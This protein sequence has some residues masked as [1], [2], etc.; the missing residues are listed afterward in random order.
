VRNRLYVV[1]FRRNAPESFQ[2]VSDATPQVISGIRSGAEMN[3]Q[4][5]VLAG[6]ERV[7]ELFPD[8]ARLWEDTS[9]DG[10]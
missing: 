2:L 7:L 9:A 5:V 8:T 10:N 1:Y 6:W 4:R 3:G